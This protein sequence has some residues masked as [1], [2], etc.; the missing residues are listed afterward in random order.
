MDRSEQAPRLDRNALLAPNWRAIL[1]AYAVA[2]LTPVAALAVV[3]AP[4]RFGILVLGT[5]AVSAGVIVWRRTTLPS[6][7]ERGL[8]SPT[9]NLAR[10][11][12]TKR[13][14]ATPVPSSRR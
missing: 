7:I 10:M 5:A 9:K 12:G 1:T 14:D 11:M 6:T 8:R 13:K 4:R 2:T 3:D